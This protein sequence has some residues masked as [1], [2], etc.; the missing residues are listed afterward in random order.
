MVG[1]GGGE[2]KKPQQGGGRSSF[3]FISV[4]YLIWSRDKRNRCV[5]A[6]SW[7][8]HWSEGTRAGSGMPDLASH[9]RLTGF[10]AVMTSLWHKLFHSH[11]G[12]LTGQRA[13]LR[14]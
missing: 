4:S 1:G 12:F 7:T 9:P 8:A 5:I 3:A 13:S 10:A 2:G 11:A 6:F 14:V